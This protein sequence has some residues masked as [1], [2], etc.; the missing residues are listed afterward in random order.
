[1][2]QSLFQ[3]A[4]PHLRRAPAPRLL[5]SVPTDLGLIA[6]QQGDLSRAQVHLEDALTAARAA[7][8]RVD[9]AIAL[10]NLGHAAIMREDY[11]TARA[12]CEESQAIARAV[13]DDWT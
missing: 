10:I 1:V 6:I 4:L 13:G 5:I 11:P 12:L 9:E 8:Y 2:A 7:C 3:A